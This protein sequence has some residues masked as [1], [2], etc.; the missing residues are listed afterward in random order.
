M[1]LCENQE[2][3]TRIG[4]LKLPRLPYE[5]GEATGCDFVHIG[6]RKACIVVPGLEPHWDDEGGDELEP[7]SHKTLGVAI[8]FQFEVDMTKL[9]KD[10]KSCFTLQFMPIRIFEFHTTPSTL[11]YPESVGSYL[12]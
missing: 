9:D 5:L 8:P 6:G 4:D 7:G 11:P 10:K 3:L 2:S 1:S 12:L